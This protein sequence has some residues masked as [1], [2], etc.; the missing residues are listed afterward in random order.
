MKKIKCLLGFHKWKFKYVKTKILDKHYKGEKEHLHNGRIC[1][2]C[3]QEQYFWYYITV[4]GWQN[5]IKL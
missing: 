1:E 3:K 2:N 4:S 5:I